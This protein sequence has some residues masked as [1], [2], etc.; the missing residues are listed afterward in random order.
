MLVLARKAFESILI[1]GNIE[2]TVVRI[3]SNSVRIG[4]E[5]PPNVVILREELADDSSTDE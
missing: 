4:I 5:A 1:G 3:D 2:V